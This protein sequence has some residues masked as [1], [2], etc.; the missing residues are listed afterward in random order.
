MMPLELLLPEARDWFEPV[1]HTGVRSH[2]IVQAA[3]EARVQVCEMEAAGSAA[4]HVHDNEQQIFHVI[5]GALDVTD[6]AGDDVVV[7]A[8]ES[9]VIPAGVPHATRNSG[10]GVCR[11]LVVT[12]RPHAGS[13]LTPSVD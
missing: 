8:G 11:Y 5:E 9:L 2:W 4:S 12:S 7:R 13:D 6:G 10:E 1:D 3:P